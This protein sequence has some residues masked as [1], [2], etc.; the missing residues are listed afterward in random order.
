MGKNATQ[1]E[2]LSTTKTNDITGTVH[3]TAV[4]WLV[5]TTPWR[6]LNTTHCVPANDHATYITLEEGVEKSLL[7]CVA[8][9][10]VHHKQLADLHTHTHTHVHART[11]THTQNP[12]VILN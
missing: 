10:G 12:S 9:V 5:H 8:L 3:D 1:Q 7:G 4:G 6:D 2:N 11:H